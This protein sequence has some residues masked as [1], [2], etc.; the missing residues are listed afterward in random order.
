MAVR[1]VVADESS[2]TTRRILAAAS[3]EFAQRGFASARVRQIVEAAQVNLA[4]VNYYFG[5]KEGLY[6]ATL[7]HL[8]EVRRGAPVNR[9]GNSP[10]ER[11][12]R[13]VFAMLERFIGGKRP[14]PLSRILAHEAM[15]PTAHHE[16]LIEDMIRPELEAVSGVVREIAG[17]DADEL[18]VTRAAV[19]VM[20]QCV[21]YLFLRGP[22]GRLHPEL[23]SGTAACKELSRHITEFSLA[24][25][26][27]LRAS[28]GPAK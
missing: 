6:S 5:G 2:G 24:G 3:E 22:L 19:S 9:R 23:T 4:A 21:F 16:R 15:N 1:N 10:E 20:G 27:R 18:D 28:G 26:A 17:P 7:R 14:S 12:Q 8:V 13:Q 25:I 11:L